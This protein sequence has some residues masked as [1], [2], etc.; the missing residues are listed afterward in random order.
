MANSNGTYGQG[1]VDGLAPMISISEVGRVFQDTTNSIAAKVADLIRTNFHITE[2]D[3]III[4]PTIAR[5]QTGLSDMTVVAYFVTKNGKNI[6]YR[7][8]GGN[9]NNGGRLNLV[10]TA[11]SS[12]NSSGQY[13]TS[14][15]FDQAI[16]SLCRVNEKGKAIMN[17]KKVPGANGVAS[18]ELDWASVLSLALGILDDDPYD[19]TIL[20]LQPIGNNNFSLMLMKKIVTTNDQKGKASGINYGRITQDLMASV[21]KGNNNHGGN[22][23]GGRSY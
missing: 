18:L 1:L 8:K 15:E 4:A 5:N 20:S 21:N 11:G 22:N 7:G 12:Y 19:F 14:A 6:F 9:N 13:G 17:I 23:G 16:K 10:Q 2:L 3:N